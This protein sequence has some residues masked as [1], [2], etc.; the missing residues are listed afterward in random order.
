VRSLL[1]TVFGFLFIGNVNAQSIDIKGKFGSDS[2]KLGETVPYT[3]TATYPTNLQIILPDSTYSFLPF[4][5][6]K[7]KFFS[8]V[9]KDNISKDSVIYYLT[10]FEID[11]IQTLKLPA[12]VIHERDCTLI[13]SNVDTIFFI[14]Q[15]GALPDSLSTSQLPLKTNTEYNPV[16]WLLNY[17][18]YSIIGGGLIVLAILV[19]LIFGKS[20]RIYFILKQLNK[21][22]EEFIQSFDEG[23]SKLKSE[24]SPVSAERIIVIWKQYMEDLVSK[25]YTKYTS[26]ELVELEKNELLLKSLHK[27]D[28]SIYGYLPPNSFESFDNLKEYSKNQFNKKIEIIRHG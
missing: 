11:S 23:M 6:Q 9:S 13:E 5:Y 25:P 28:Q 27:I 7:K 8:T 4:E 26:K 15:V 19:W 16:Q 14:P 12:F 22:H 10:T 18:L 2:I 20:I 21:K 1:I 24:L 3:L 17:P